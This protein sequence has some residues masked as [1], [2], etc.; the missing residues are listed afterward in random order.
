MI[1]LRRHS[2]IRLLAHAALKSRCREAAPLDDAAKQRILSPFADWLN[3]A[4]TILDAWIAPQMCGQAAST[5]VRLPR[6][7]C[8]APISDLGV[9]DEDKIFSGLVGAGA[10][11][12]DLRSKADEQ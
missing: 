3:V 11:L 2:I 1:N 8:S 5:L 4:W 9:S 10:L 12:I 6:H 7:V